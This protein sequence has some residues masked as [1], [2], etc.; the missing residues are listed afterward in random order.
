MSQDS[1]F[2]PYVPEDFVEFWTE[3]QQE[4]AR[5]PLY[6][7]R[8]SIIV[9]SA[10]G[11]RVEKI[12]F[13]GAQDRLVEGWIAF[14]AGARR[15]PSF[16]WVPPYGR[17]SLLPNEY[18]TRADM[19]SMSLNFHN[20]QAFHQEKYQIG[21]GYFSSGAESRETWIFRR[22]MIDVLAAL[23]VLQ[24]QPEVD[25]DRIGSMGMS[26]GGGI[27]LWAA[28]WS[29]IVKAVCADMPFLGAMRQS[30]NVNAYRYPL[31]EVVDFMETIPIGRERVMHTISYF[32][33]LNQ[34]TQVK[35]P[36][37][38]TLGLKDPACRPETVRAIYAAIPVEKRLFEY[39]G[40]H[41]WHTEMIAN[42]RD[43]LQENMG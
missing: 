32:D 9:D 17:E 4:A 23:K 16:L 5:I 21:R 13:R 30:L 41:D 28:A 37:Q 35:V 15:I 22:M 31:K 18:G 12:E 11:H 27:S 39:A 33:T 14:P 43:W 34:A 26:Q 20:E 40:G 3:V 42:N 25:E 10:H 7:K 8:E 6:F 36:T 24:A 19:C 29:P 1:E 2:L 38:V